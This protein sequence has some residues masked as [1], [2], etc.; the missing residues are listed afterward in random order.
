MV[1]RGS[2]ETSL[3]NGDWQEHPPCCHGEPD[4]HYSAFPV[5]H[6]DMVSRH[7]KSWHANAHAVGCSDCS[8]SDSGVRRAAG[9][10]STRPHL[11][12][13]GGWKSI[14]VWASGSV[15]SGG[16]FASLMDAEESLA[17]ELSRALQSA[18]PSGGSL[19]EDSVHGVVKKV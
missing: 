17:V 1:W 18:T 15:Y 11:R 5:D 16:S 10:Q 3:A 14:N 8:A 2:S 7:A 19:D 9:L 12:G 13:F 6:H 4:S